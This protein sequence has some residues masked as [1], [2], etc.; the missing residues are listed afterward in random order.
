MMMGLYAPQWP[1]E[2]FVSHFADTTRV[3]RRSEYQRGAR[4][5][6]SLALPE[7]PVVRRMG[8]LVTEGV[9]GGSMVRVKASRIRPLRAFQHSTS[10]DMKKQE[11]SSHRI[12]QF[13][14]VPDGNP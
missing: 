11:L 3:R 10:D 9:A 14:R 7:A 13:D 5:Q 2:D 12:T 4:Q 6:A 1:L 8:N